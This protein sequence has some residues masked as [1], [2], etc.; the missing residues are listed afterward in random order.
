MSRLS[1]VLFLALAITCSAL[2]DKFSAV[3]Q[4][5]TSDFSQVKKGI[6]LV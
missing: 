4:L 1:L 3:K 5:T 6:W 2:Y